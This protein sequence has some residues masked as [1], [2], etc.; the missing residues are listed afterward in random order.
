[1]TPRFT[2][3]SARWV[4]PVTSAPIRD[5]AVLIDPSGVIAAVGPL[6]TVPFPEGAVSD[7]LGEA[8]LLPGLVNAHAHLDLCMFRGCLEDLEFPDW[9]ARLLELKRDA[10][11]GDDDYRAAARWGCVEALAAGITAIGT[12]DDGAGSL[13][14]LRES[15]QRGVVYREVFGPAASQAGPALAR[16]REQIESMRAL[17]TDLVRVGV[18]PHA[19]YTVSEP[20][21]A[22]VARLA[23]AESLPLAVHAAESA[24]E[25][26]LV[27]HGDGVFADRLRAR[28]ITTTRAR[29]TVALLE[30]T[31]ILE[32]APLLVHAVRVDAADIERMAACGAAVAHCPTANARLGHG[33]APVLALRDAGVG[34]GLG[35]DS[36]ASNNRMDVLEEARLA[37]LL[38][39]SN[40]GSATAL[41][42][43]VLLRMATLDGAR[44]LRIAERAGSL[45]AGKDADLCAVRL[46]GPHARPL[47]DPLAALFHS[48]RAP[49]VMLTM[50]RGQTLY[51]DGRVL[52]LDPDR[53]RADIEI[54]GARVRRAAAAGR[55]ASMASPASP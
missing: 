33:I 50:V 1:V 27:A 29:S 5:G 21:F 54:V 16:L 14:A 44:A 7:D 23:G 9:I 11:L 41:P 42:A 15:G 38:Q 2:R 3:F 8:V 46:T 20:L 45:E 26:E 12:T 47:H 48:T 51:R 13:A 55:S 49:D 22:A 24:A 18:S 43:D 40:L 30:Q 25:A 31:G 19:P 53:A 34:V 6:E 17:E 36:V 39:R 32:L 52:T 37:Q 35:T 4:L 28:G 10:A